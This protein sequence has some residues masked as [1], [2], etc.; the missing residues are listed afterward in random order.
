MNSTTHSSAGGESDTRKIF[1]IAR[2]DSARAATNEWHGASTQPN[3]EDASLLKTNTM[4]TNSLM[5][6]ASLAAIA[7]LFGGFTSTASAGPGPMMF[8]PVKSAK[9]AGKLKEGTQIAISCG[10]CHGISV[11]TVD[12]DRSYLQGYTCPMC[13]VTFKTIMPGGG[14]RGTVGLYSYSDGAGTTATLTAHN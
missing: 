7:L 11:M 2:K 3:S 9:E 4:K 12:K 5:K 6:V 10:K 14:G 8:H 13:K 1:E